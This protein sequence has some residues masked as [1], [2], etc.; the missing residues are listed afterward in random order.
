ME[1]PLNVIQKILKE[2]DR[3]ET[4]SNNSFVEESDVSNLDSS[5]SR[6]RVRSHQRNANSISIQKALSSSDGE[7]TISL[8]HSRNSIPDQNVDLKEKIFEFIVNTLGYNTRDITNESPE[9]TATFNVIANDGSSSSMNSDSRKSSQSITSP[10]SKESVKSESQAISRRMDLDKHVEIL[11]A[12]KGSVLVK[13]GDRQ[14]DLFLVIHGLLEL[15]IESQRIWTEQVKL[16]TF[17]DRYSFT[18]K[19]GCLAGY[20][21]ALTGTPSMVTVTAKIDSCIVCVKRSFLERYVEKHNVRMA[22]WLIHFSTKV[23]FDRIFY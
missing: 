1:I 13:Q 6:T 16:P 18:I 2:F 17:K 15:S 10:E 14:S 7:P 21:S 3:P 8:M 5:P 22:I 4:G 11:Y 9:Q 19:T 12:P 23:H 20:I